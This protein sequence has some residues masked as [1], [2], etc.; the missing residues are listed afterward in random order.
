M[1]KPVLLRNCCHESL[2]KKVCEKL[3]HTKNS[4]CEWNKETTSGIKFRE[5]NHALFCSP[6]SWYAEICNQYLE[7]N[8]D[9]NLFSGVVGECMNVPVDGSCDNVKNE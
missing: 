8:F 5:M 4:I 3:N 9:R 1:C 6:L 2:N 7:C